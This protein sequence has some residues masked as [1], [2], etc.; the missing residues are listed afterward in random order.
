MLPPGVTPFRSL[1]NQYD[2]FIPPEFIAQSRYADMAAYTNTLARRAEANFHNRILNVLSIIGNWRLRP[3]PYRWHRL[4]LHGETL[5]LYRQK[6][7]EAF[8]LCN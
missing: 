2:G 3:H 7:C 5:T 4:R 1:E 8:D 6:A